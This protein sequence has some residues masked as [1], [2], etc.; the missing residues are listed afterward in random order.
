MKTEYIVATAFTAW[1]LA[2]R[3]NKLLAQGYKL[4]GGIC[5]T[6]GGY[7]QALTVCKE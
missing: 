6:W 4:E 2:R 5:R 3:V 1:G 7:F